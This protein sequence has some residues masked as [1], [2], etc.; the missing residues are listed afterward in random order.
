ME[1]GNVFQY[2]FIIII[3]HH[4]R[5]A[6]AREKMS[7]FGILRILEILDRHLMKFENDEISLTKLATN[8]W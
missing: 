7:R 1:P 8:V 2:L 6:E 3:A 4:S 5:T